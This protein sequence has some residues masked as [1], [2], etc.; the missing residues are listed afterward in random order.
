M[1]YDLLVK[2]GRIID[3]SGM[4]SFMG[5][6]AVTGGRIVEIGR[7]DGPSRRTIN[8]DGLAVAPGF[9]DNH[10]HFDAQALWDPL[11]TFACYHGTT[12][13]IN[14][15][16]SLGLAPARPEDQYALTSM[17]SRVEAIPLKSLQAGVEWSW[18]T[19]PEYLDALDRRLGVNVGALIGYSAVRRYVMGDAVYEA[20]A[21]P[22]QMELITG[23][24][25]EGIEAGAL[26]LSFER[27]IRH[28]DI[29]GRL[30]PCNVSSSDELVAAAEAL[31][32][33]GGAIQ[34]GDAERSET[35]EG[36]L[37]RMA[38][39]SGRPLISNFSS[40]DEGENGVRIYPMVSPFVQSPTRWTLLTVATFDAL[41][42]WLALTDTPRDQK[43]RVLEDRGM[44]ARLRADA[45]APD[46]RRPEGGPG[47]DWDSIYV[48]SVVKDENRRFQERSIADIAGER[49]ADRLDTF[50][51]LALDEDL[52]TTFYRHSNVGVDAK[53]A[54]LNNPHVMPGL[55]DGGAHVIRRCQSH[56]T[57]F[58]LSYWVREV[59]AMTL[60]EV[61]RK[62]TFMPASV[63]GLPD[64][65][66]IRPGLAGDL[67]VFDPDTVGPTEM[68]EVADYP[69]GAVRKRR[70]SKGV[71]YTIVNGE[72]LI[73]NG[74]HTGSYPGRVVR[75][76]ASRRS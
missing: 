75:S 55:S 21:T 31:R 51:D 17:L 46:V 12:T 34:F 61:V 49:G 3:G 15:N 4:P 7:L 14:G 70:L 25:K 60:E 53:A 42:A 72:V 26:G 65:G 67:V 44:R 47:I 23:L 37:S 57:T 33:V 66:L 24:I 30:L 28:M 56:Y 43:R 39:A 2:N 48:S 22:E 5:D 64:R 45:D 76:A 38:R 19:I 10:C 74:E 68:D 59:G 29:E 54:V 27:N 40:L 6:V 13:V 11:C 71:E 50:L 20:Q 58:M 36:L 32:E 73:E 41:P 8:A 35:K 69:A 63:F 9:I 16:C 18:E 62:L 52:A 1:A